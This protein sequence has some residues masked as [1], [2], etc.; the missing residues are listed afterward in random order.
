MKTI[1]DHIER[2]KGKPHHIRKQIAFGMAAS[3]TSL[4]ALLWFVHA[5][6][7]DRFALQN[8][9]FADLLEE[10]AVIVTD[11]QNS[12]QNVAGA[13]AAFQNA[14]APA[15]IEIVDTASST[16]KAKPSEQ[17]TIPF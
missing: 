12:S 3:I 2:V 9:S 8:S 15:H 6:S 16:R 13:A 10:K 7:S 14:S 1:F 5:I 11:G 4:I 17:T